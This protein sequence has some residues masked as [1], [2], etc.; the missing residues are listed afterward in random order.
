MA[1]SK[2]TWRRPGYEVV[3]VRV[4]TAVVEALDAEVGRLKVAALVDGLGEPLKATRT[5]VILNALAEH[6]KLL[7]GS[8]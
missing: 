1:K 3:S 7:P 5:T 2:K 4:R 6:L 8:K